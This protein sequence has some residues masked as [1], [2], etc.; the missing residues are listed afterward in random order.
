VS[1]PIK[2]SAP[3]TGRP[4]RSAHAFADAGLGRAVADYL[5]RERAEMMHVQAELD[6]DTPYKADP[7]EPQERHDRL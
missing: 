6:A 7:E 3:A 2:F 1:P 4:S 5:R